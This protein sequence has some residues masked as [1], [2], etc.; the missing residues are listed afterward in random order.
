MA[1]VVQGPPYNG[2][3]RQLGG[4]SFQVVFNK[5]D[6][7]SLYICNSCHQSIFHMD[8]FPDWSI[9]EIGIYTCALPDTD[10]NIL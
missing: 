1:K 10:I 2:F 9:I 8:F 6:L 4:P 7:N 5:T 3:H